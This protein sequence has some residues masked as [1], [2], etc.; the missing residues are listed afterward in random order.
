MPRPAPDEYAEHF[1]SYIDRVPDGDVLVHLER[2]GSLTRALFAAASEVKGAYAYAS[3][4][5]TVKRVLQH[6]TDGER[7]FGYRALCIARGE[8]AALPGFDENLY[9]AND[10]SEG[11]RLGDIVAEFAAVRSATLALF[12]G[13]DAAA[14]ARRGIANGKATSVHSLSWLT[15]G[16]E[17]H[18]LAVLRARYGLQ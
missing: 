14:L 2:Q 6:I 9:A 1:Q 11:R 10:G 17:L 16:H 18:H 13:F 8:V 12:S 4:K 7:V 5:W 3:G 15:A